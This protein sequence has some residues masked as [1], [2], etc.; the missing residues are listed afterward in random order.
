MGLHRSLS[1]RYPFACA[2]CLFL[3]HPDLCKNSRSKTRG[4]YQQCSV[5]CDQIVSSEYQIL[6]GFPFSGRGID[7]TAQ[8]SCT[9]LLSGKGTI[10]ILET[11]SLEPTDSPI[12]VAPISA[13]EVE[14]R[15]CHPQIFAELTSQ[16]PAPSSSHRNNRLDPKESPVFPDDIPSPFPLPV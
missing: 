9:E 4:L 6:R 15:L 8:K 11:V 2:H 12:T 13:C 10:I 1:R 7:I 3:I 16:Y 5:L 14:G